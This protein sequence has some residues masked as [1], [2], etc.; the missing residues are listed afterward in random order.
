KQ[1][2]SPIAQAR[3]AGKLLLLAGDGVRSVLRQRASHARVCR[4]PRSRHGMPAELFGSAPAHAAAGA[5]INPAR[6]RYL[7]RLRAGHR[8]SATTSP[9]PS[10]YPLAGP[11]GSARGQFAPLARRNPAHIPAPLNFLAQTVFS[12]AH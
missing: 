11:G 7:A 12:A 9:T 4:D 2:G 1:T 6:P 5:P 3:R 10:R 8:S